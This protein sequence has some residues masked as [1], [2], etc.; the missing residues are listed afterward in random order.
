MMSSLCYSF[1]PWWIDWPFFGIDLLFSASLF[2]FKIFIWFPLWNFSDQKSS[3]FQNVVQNQRYR[4]FF[5]FFES[6]CCRNWG[7]V[8]S[9]LSFTMSY[10][11]FLFHR[12]LLAWKPSLCHESC[13]DRTKLSLS[14]KAKLDSH[15]GS[16]HLEKKQEL[17]E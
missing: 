10:L 15:R 2:W 6:W 14:L 16:T 4:I 9:H 12:Y 5:L 8:I 3:F 11:L 1:L 7:F 17:F 13:I